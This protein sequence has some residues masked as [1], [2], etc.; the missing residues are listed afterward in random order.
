ML[1]Y[2]VV[3]LHVIVCVFLVLVV[4]L[5]SGKGA[6]LAGAFGGG[7]TQT[8]FG[9]RGPASFLTRMTTVVA[10]IFMVTSIGLSLMGGKRSV[11][12]KSIL[13]TSGRASAPA[14]EQ[15][16]TDTNAAPASIPTPDQIEEQ[17]RQIQENR[18]TAPADTMPEFAPVE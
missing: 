3:A 4:L 10:I 18:Q 8:A 11:D 15:Q 7:A 13:E 6:D 17:I 14:Q 16:K 12:D 9:S 2:F 1:Y 5:Q